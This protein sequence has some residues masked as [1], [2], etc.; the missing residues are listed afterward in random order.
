MSDQRVEDLCDLLSFPV[1]PSEIRQP[2]SNR[3]HREINNKRQ[4]E[5]KE[6][7]RRAI[8]ILTVTETRHTL[9]THI[10]VR[11]ETDDVK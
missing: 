1:K 7:I 6:S 3:A 2:N 9:Y 5:G 10:T 4:D 8:P 11:A